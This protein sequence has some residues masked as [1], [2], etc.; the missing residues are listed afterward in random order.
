LAAGGSGAGGSNT[1]K[2][3]KVSF[4]KGRS[5]ERIPP[6]GMIGETSGRDTLFEGY[7][8]SDGGASGE[9][10]IGTPGIG[11]SGGNAGAFGAVAGNATGSGARGNGSGS[12]RWGLERATVFGGPTSA[13]IARG[14]AG[15]IDGKVCDIEKILAEPAVVGSFASAAGAVWPIECATSEPYWKPFK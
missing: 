7:G 1:G 8:G 11:G 2:I 4:G 14:L 15:T 12:G 9:K 10:G 3:G 6:A 5:S 13:A